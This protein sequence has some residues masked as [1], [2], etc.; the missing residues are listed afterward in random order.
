MSCAFI[1]GHACIC[2]LNVYNSPVM[3]GPLLRRSGMEAE[4]TQIHGDNQPQAAPELKTPTQVPA[5][6]SCDGAEM[7]RH[8]YWNGSDQ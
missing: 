5:A 4:T 8:S 2:L 6:R 3:F 7:I 1:L